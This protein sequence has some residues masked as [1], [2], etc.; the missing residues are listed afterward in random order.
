[1]GYK[2]WSEN[3]TIE[4]QLRK[5]M[6]DG[7][8]KLSVK[9][10]Y[11]CGVRTVYGVCNGG[12]SDYSFRGY[13]WGERNET[14]MLFGPTE[15]VVNLVRS[16]LIGYK[17]FC[18]V[19]DKVVEISDL[20]SMERITLGVTFEKELEIGDELVVFKPEGNY[21]VGGEDAHRKVTH[22]SKDGVVAYTIVGS[23]W[24][25]NGYF[26]NIKNMND[27]YI[28]LPDGQLRK[29]AKKR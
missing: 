26:I 18:F 22:I 14:E 7:C 28:R 9:H 6:V 12:Y 20:T 19:E 13:R 15:Y 17:Y 8:P 2:P 21:I 11:D 29:I 3:I 5:A 27:W 24:P 10:V 16:N 4:E 23:S 1:M 25:C